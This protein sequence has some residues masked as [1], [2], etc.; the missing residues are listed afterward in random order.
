MQLQLY[1][2]FKEGA[3]RAKRQPSLCY[4]LYEETSLEVGWTFYQTI[5]GGSRRRR[6]QGNQGLDEEFCKVSCKNPSCVRTFK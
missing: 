6:Q 2:A 5:F 4:Y 1:L 3:I